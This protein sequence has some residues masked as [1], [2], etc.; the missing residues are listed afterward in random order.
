MPEVEPLA[1][2]LHEVL[3]RSRI[4]VQPHRAG[5]GDAER[6]EQIDGIEARQQLDAPPAGELGQLE[7]AELGAGV[8]RPDRVVVRHQRV[9]PVDGDELLGQRKRH[10]VVIGRRTRNA[11]E[12]V[13]VVER[14][15]H[16]LQLPERTRTSSFAGR[17][18]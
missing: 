12:Q 6:V 7:L 13:V 9:H 11:A 14:R 1:V 18:W 10:A 17:R 16:V 3:Q 2:V 5:M 8:R 4:V 15:E